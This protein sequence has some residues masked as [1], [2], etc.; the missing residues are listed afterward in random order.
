MVQNPVTG[1]LDMRIAR[2]DSFPV[3]MNGREIF[4]ASEL[5]RTETE[6]FER[7]TQKEVKD[8]FLQRMKPVMAKML[9]GNYALNG[10]II[11]DHNGKIVFIEKIRISDRDWRDNKTDAYAAQAKLL[12]K[13]L[14]DIVEKTGKK[15]T[16][17]KRGDKAEIVRLESILPARLTFHVQ[18]KNVTIT[19]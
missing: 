1:A 11:L 16:P 18:D 14:N 2:I 9:D 5:S 12:E 8:Y 6:A 7:T 13:E 17:V 15:F 19:E 10:Y 4:R 3:K